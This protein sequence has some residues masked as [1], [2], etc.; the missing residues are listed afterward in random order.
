MQSTRRTSFVAACALAAAA[1][2]PQAAPAQP[3]GIDPQADKLLK[4]S[5]TFLAGQKRFSVETRNTIEVVLTSGQKL[6]FGNASTAWVQRPDRLRAERKGDLV[7]QLF[8][9]DGK[10]LT[11]YNP[12]QK[13]YATVAAPGT[14]DQI[15]LCNPAEVV[16]F[17]E[18]Q[19]RELPARFPGIRAVTGLDRFRGCADG[20]G[21]GRRCP[22]VA[23]F[24]RRQ[25]SSGRYTPTARHS[26][27]VLHG[28]APGPRPGADAGSAADAY[29][30]GHPPCDSDA[31][32]AGRDRSRRA[33]APQ[34]HPGSQSPA[35]PN[36]APACFAEGQDCL[37]I[38]PHRPGCVL[39]HERGRHRCDAPA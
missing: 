21:R 3:A 15:F 34:S 37:Q 38:G 2:L 4:A 28:N 31:C 35:Q 9:Y 26:T 25:Y 6:Q 17:T 39:H 32:R 20:G 22:V 24:R 14:L 30:D 7:D 8:L 10:S 36:P 29:T 19:N 12:G 27:A 13:Y 23:T 1:V 33:A 11:L 5:T 16:R 18:R